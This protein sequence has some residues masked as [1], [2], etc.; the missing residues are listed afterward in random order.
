MRTATLLVEGLLLL[1]ASAAVAMAGQT[2]ERTRLQPKQVV[3]SPED[4]AAM[5]FKRP[6]HQAGAEKIQ[7]RAGTKRRAKKK[8]TDVDRD[9]NERQSAQS[10]AR[11][12]LRR[13]Q[14]VT[15]VSGVPATDEAW[16]SLS[17]LLLAESQ[18]GSAA[19]RAQLVN[20]AANAFLV[21]RSGWGSLVVA[22]SHASPMASLLF[23]LNASSPLPDDVTEVE[24]LR[25][26]SRSSDVA[27]DLAKLALGWRYLATGRSVERSCHTAVADFYLSA[28]SSSV[29]AADLASA[30]LRATHFPFVEEVWL[31]DDWLEG[32]SRSRQSGAE[33]VALQAKADGGD[34]AAILMLAELY[35]YGDNPSVAHD[36]EKALAYYRKAAEQGNVRAAHNLALILQR[37]GGSS[38][39]VAVDIA[40]SAELLGQAASAGETILVDCSLRLPNHCVS[41]CKSRSTYHEFEHTGIPALCIADS[42]HWLLR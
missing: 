5:G 31:W 10:R 28:A 26:A 21:N 38:G 40:E 1:L 2:E 12:L 8:A 13:E 32:F 29:R 42:C 7:P 20:D 15:E 14:E 11:E 35:F 17:E 22:L 25:F 9:E 36:Q 39:D 41:C 37:G 18:L 24:L 6:H 19:A 30:E 4:A 33:V 3:L 27:G 16:T 34:D 23:G